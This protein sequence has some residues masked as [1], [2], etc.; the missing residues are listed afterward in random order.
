MARIILQF[1]AQFRDSAQRGRAADRAGIPA[2]APSAAGGNGAC[3]VEYLRA[4]PE[5]KSLPA[6]FS[7]AAYG[8]KEKKE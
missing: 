4:G 2:F 8:G 5:A 1:R 7:A 3:L 6:E